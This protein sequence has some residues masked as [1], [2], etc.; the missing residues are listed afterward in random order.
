MDS[1]L[2][3]IRNSDFHL[4]KKKIF[5]SQVFLTDKKKRKS[6]DI[7]PTLESRKEFPTITRL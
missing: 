6:R 1:G 5:F 2:I 3:A 7:P 4:L